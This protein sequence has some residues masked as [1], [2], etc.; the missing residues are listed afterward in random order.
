MYLS[1][2][3]QTGVLAAALVLGG[4]GAATAAPQG[5]VAQ[6]TQ[7][8]ELFTGTGSSSVIAHAL[9]LAE[10]NARA[11]A[12][13]AGYEDAECEVRT[14]I[15]RVQIPARPPLFLAQVIIGCTHA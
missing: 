9:A 1:R 5:A 4:A 11:A 15:I 6:A 7:D 13:D 8:V 14:Q 3:L 12:A 10:A 2:V